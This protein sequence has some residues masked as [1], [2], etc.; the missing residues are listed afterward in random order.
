MTSEGC[1]LQFGGR[2]SFIPF[3]HKNQEAG[4]AKQTI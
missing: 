2:S 1:I 3:G 4:Y